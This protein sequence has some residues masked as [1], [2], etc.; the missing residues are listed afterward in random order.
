MKD[1]TL[2]VPCNSFGPLA[3][4]FE[5]N[6]ILVTGYIAGQR[7]SSA[8][9]NTTVFKSFPAVDATPRK[10]LTKHIRNAVVG[11]AYHRHQL[12]CI[13]PENGSSKHAFV[14]G[15]DKIKK[16]CCFGFI[17]MRSKLLS[18]PRLRRIILIIW[19]WK[20]GH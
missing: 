16:S 12:L 20:V 15:T 8:A 1:I 3:S 7:L 14:T 11:P 13:A 19:Y 18:V 4:H 10:T 5:V 2:V 9:K 6:N 17:L